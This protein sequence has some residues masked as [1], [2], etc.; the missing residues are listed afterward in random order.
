MSDSKATNQESSKDRN[1]EIE[2]LD[3]KNEKNINSTKEISD[4]NSENLK[5]EEEN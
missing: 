5:K 4:P 3:N 2:E 1:N